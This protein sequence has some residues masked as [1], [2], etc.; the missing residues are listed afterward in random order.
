VRGLL[1]HCLGHFIS[2]AATVLLPRLQHAV[3]G[4][5]RGGRGEGGVYKSLQVLWV[6]GG[7]ARRV[8]QR[9]LRRRLYSSA[10]RACTRCEQAAAAAAAAAVTLATCALLLAAHEHA[11]E[12]RGPP[13]A[14]Q[15][16]HGAGRQLLRTR[17]TQLHP[18]GGGGGG[19]RTTDCES[20]STLQPS[21]RHAAI[22]SAPADAVIRPHT[23]A[24]R[25]G[26]A[27]HRQD[28]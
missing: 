7:G 27:S 4:R 24:P 9:V 22:D 8:G 11:E 5:G 19:S 28:Q 16:D 17:V 21:H 23:A 1:S 26:T 6:V 2:A 25:C 12:Q 10:R 18:G 3:R 15:H 14:R 20:C 13:H